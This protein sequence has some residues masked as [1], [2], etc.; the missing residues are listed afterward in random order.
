MN[1]ELEVP[2][3]S[4]FLVI[5]ASLPTCE[6]FEE[7]LR[8]SDSV[9]RGYF[10]GTT[11]RSDLSFVHVPRVTPIKTLLK[12]LVQ[13]A[14]PPTSPILSIGTCPFHYCCGKMRCFVLDARV[15]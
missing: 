7:L 10:L 1:C 13:F 6:G 14:T 11:F 9:R 4:E 15:L 8:G 3:T 2:V 12:I 5:R